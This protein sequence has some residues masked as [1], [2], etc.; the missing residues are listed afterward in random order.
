MKVVIKIEKEIEAGRK[1]T[2]YIR[3]LPWAA[4]AVLEVSVMD[5]ILHSPSLDP[6]ARR[7]P[8]PHQL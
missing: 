3:V 6:V 7:E 2:R 5:H 8:S 4:S 1:T